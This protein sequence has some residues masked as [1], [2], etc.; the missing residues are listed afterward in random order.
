MKR[1]AIPL[2]FAAL[3]L[4]LGFMLW[5]KEPP[6]IVLELRAMP[7]AARVEYSGEADA[8]LTVVHLCDWNYVPR[9]LCELEGIS[10]DDVCNVAAA[11]QKSELAIA[12]QL[13]KAHGIKAVYSE[14]LSEQ[15]RPAF[16]LRLD[17]LKDLP[18]PIAA[19][20]ADTVKHLT[21]EV[22]TP[23]RLWLA[24]DIGHVLPLEDEKALQDAK[25]VRNS[26]IVFDEA[27][28]NARRKAMVAQLPRYG[29]ALIVLGS[30]HDLGPH[31]REG[32]LYV[33]VTPR[34]GAE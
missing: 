11:V 5:P 19:E 34:G 26:V 33:K 17:A 10:F 20:D 12:R 2:L 7:E 6:A 31:L 27:K 25:P 18:P 23:G 9:A 24:G 4:F 22:G 29:L 32:T 8:D 28:V 14:G 21:L 1:K 3:C 16:Q 30:S 15:T 13:I